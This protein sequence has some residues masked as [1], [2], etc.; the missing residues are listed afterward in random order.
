MGFVDRA[1]WSGGFGDGIWWRCDWCGDCLQ[2]Q[3]G[4][5]HAGAGRSLD[6]DSDP[7]PVWEK[8][9]SCLLKCR[10][11]SEIVA[12]AGIAAY[13]E[14]PHVVT[15][16]DGD[17]VAEEMET[18]VTYY[19]RYVNPAPPF[20]EVPSGCPEGV[21]EQLGRVF[22]LYWHDAGAALNAVRSSVEK[23]LDALG[24]DTA[25]NLHERIEDKFA[26]AEPELST[27]L[28]AVK[29]LG[30]PGSHGDE[31]TVGKNDV[32]DA[33]E[34]LAHVLDELYV[35]RPRREKTKS[36]VNEI[37]KNRGPRARRRR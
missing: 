19:P 7:A 11:C 28:L 32:L 24:V 9:F 13:E 30:N 17:V 10:K 4:S 15:D 5:V 23:L 2:V 22:S 35:Q 25:R 14:V 12:V 36:L 31:T 33:L 21:K 20:F 8:R 26:P 27:H 16:P 34:V 1:R 29:Y 37:N 18:V 3:S 6:H